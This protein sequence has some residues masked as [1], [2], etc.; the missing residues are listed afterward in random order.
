M[1]YQDYD[2]LIKICQHSLRKGCDLNIEQIADI[3]RMIRVLYNE[4]SRR[5]SNVVDRSKKMGKRQGI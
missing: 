3:D 4:Q 5:K 2:L 1:K